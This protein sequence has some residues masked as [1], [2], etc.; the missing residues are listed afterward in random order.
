MSVPRSG[1]EKHV[2]GGLKEA[3]TEGVIK[4]PI[5]QITNVNSK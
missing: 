1:V 3:K 4:L 2:H 5:K